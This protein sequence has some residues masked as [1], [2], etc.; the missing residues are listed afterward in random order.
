MI[1]AGERQKLYVSHLYHNCDYAHVIFYRPTDEPI[2][3]IEEILL[4]RDGKECHEKDIG[5]I[6]DVINDVLHEL[7]AS[8][9]I[10]D[11][12]VETFRQILILDGRIEVMGEEYWKVW[13]KGETIVTNCIRL[14]ELQ[15][16]KLHQICEHHDKNLIGRSWMNAI[17]EADGE[18]YAVIRHGADE[19][20]YLWTPNGWV[21]LMR[22]EA[23]WH[24][25]R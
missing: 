5:Y 3:V 9:S 10:W 20:M 13:K 22:A 21:P 18:L 12:I 16:L 4:R 7:I 11:R 8:L 23:P 15:W 6:N 14:T 19:D 1:G 24:L 25:V 2:F 17:V